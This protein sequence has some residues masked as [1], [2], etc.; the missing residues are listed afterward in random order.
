LVLRHL[1]FLSPGLSRTIKALVGSVCQ[2]S[3]CSGIFCIKSPDGTSLVATLVLA[4]SYLVYELHLFIEA[5]ASSSPK[6]PS[7]FRAFFPTAA[8]DVLDDAV[9]HA[10][11]EGDDQKAFPA[12]E[13][14]KRVE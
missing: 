2:L 14:L 7:L 5:A 9:E 13:C 12:S 4:V 6:L 10:N 1:P 3:M 11:R 8:N